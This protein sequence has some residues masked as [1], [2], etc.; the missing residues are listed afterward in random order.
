[1]I[2]ALEALG[3]RLW[4]H[5]SPLYRSENFR[6]NAE[7]VF[8]YVMSMSM[9][10]VHRDVEFAVDGLPP[11]SGPEDWGYDRFGISESKTLVAVPPRA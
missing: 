1:M 8:D 6:G 9:V 10:G 7:N 3:Y 2:A 11:V 4:W 5:A